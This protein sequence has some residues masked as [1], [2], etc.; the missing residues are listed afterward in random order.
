MPLGNLLRSLRNKKN[1]ISAVLDFLPCGPVIAG[2]YM[3][4][5]Q[6]HSKCIGGY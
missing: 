2:L 4:T 1:H 5:Y 3:L 6:T